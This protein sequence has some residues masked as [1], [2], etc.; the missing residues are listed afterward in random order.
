[1]AFAF[2]VISQHCPASGGGALFQLDIER[3][4]GL[5]GG[6]T[7]KTTTIYATIP[8]A[9]DA[10][11]LA[12]HGAERCAFVDASGKRHQTLGAFLEAAKAAKKP[13]AVKPPEAQQ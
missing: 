4:Y 7:W 3:N 2:G 11:I 13:V 10:L 8:E 9:V 1:M 12:R 5:L 6:G